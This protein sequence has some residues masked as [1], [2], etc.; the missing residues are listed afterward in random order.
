VAFL[1]ANYQSILVV[2]LAALESV[3]LV[4]HILGKPNSSAIGSVVSAVKG[5]PGVKD[6][7]IG[8]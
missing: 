2:V 5:V 1:I 4:L 8:A 6:P 7:N 3:N